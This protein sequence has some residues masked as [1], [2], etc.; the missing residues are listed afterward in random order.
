MSCYD[1]SCV[2]KYLKYKPDHTDYVCTDLISLSPVMTH[3]HSSCSGIQ[4]YNQSRPSIIYTFIWLQI[5]TSSALTTSITDT[6]SPVLCLDL[7]TA[8]FWINAHEDTQQGSRVQCKLL[9]LLQTG[10]SGVEGWPSVSKLC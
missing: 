9:Y 8:W 5:S 7:C 1:T 4:P 6:I 3:C 2:K 10:V